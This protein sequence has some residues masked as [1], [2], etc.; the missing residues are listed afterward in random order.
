VPHLVV[1]ALDRQLTGR[2]APLATGLTDAVVSVYGEWARDLVVVQLLA[3][4]P[5]RW[6]VG[7]RTADDPPPTVS[8]GINE[9]ALQRPDGPSVVARLAAAVTDVLATVLGEHLRAGILVEFRPQ[10]PHLTAVG[11]TL[12]HTDTRS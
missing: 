4:P 2:E 9:R 10:P 1:L 3:V 6:A 8:F 7:G 12:T 5:G 11:G